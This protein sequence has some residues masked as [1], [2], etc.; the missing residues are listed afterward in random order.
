MYTREYSFSP[1]MKEDQ[2]RVRLLTSQVGQV[3]EKQEQ[4]FQGNRE[5]KSVGNLLAD[6][7]LLLRFQKGSL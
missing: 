2:H 1:N 6:K 3:T 5:V 7:V 4:D